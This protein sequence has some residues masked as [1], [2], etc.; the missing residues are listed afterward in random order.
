MWSKFLPEDKTQQRESLAQTSYACHVDQK[1]T[2]LA[3]LTKLDIGLGAPFNVFGSRRS[4][5]W[6][7]SHSKADPTDSVMLGTQFNQVV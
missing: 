7:M 4:N 5:A 1:T 2:Q 3:Q 6:Q